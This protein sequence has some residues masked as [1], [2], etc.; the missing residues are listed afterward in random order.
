[1]KRLTCRVLINLSYAELPTEAKQYVD[2]LV[3]QKNPFASKILEGVYE[4]VIE[5]D[6]NDIECLL[7]DAFIDADSDRKVGCFWY[8]KTKIFLF[9]CSL[10]T[11]VAVPNLLKKNYCLFLQSLVIASYL[12]KEGYVILPLM[13]E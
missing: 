13:G 11:G 10:L 1:M 5:A 7:S 2:R 9:V 12:A 6:D 8:L 4:S 3:K